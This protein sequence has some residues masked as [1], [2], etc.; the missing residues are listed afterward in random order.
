MDNKDCQKQKYGN[1]DA[2]KK[3]DCIAKLPKEFI[4]IYIG[5]STYYSEKYRDD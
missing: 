3:V 5:K 1:N 4:D 2:Y